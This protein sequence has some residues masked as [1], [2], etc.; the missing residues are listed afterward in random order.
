M[1][2]VSHQADFVEFIRTELRQDLI[3]RRRYA[4]G[5]WKMVVI[6][7]LGITAFLL[8]DGF[9]SA[10]NNK[11]FLSDAV[12]LALIGGTTASVLGLFAIVANYLFPQAQSSGGLF[13]RVANYVLSSERSNNSAPER[14]KGPEGPPA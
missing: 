3:E 4:D 12:I 10:Y 2:D 8:L 1:P 14:K 7:L 6:W 9:W 5:L 11:P 13:E